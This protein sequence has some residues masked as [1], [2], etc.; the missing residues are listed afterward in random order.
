MRAAAVVVC[1]TLAMAASLDESVLR[2]SMSS[3]VPPKRAPVKDA[4]YNES[5]ALSRVYSAGIA[6][7]PGSCIADWSCGPCSNPNL[8]PTKPVAYLYDETLNI[9]GYVTLTDAGVLISFRGTVSSSLQDW[10]DDLSSIVT[11]DLP[12]CDGCQVGSGFYDAYLSVRPQ[13]LAALSSVQSAA[14]QN[15]QITGHSL[16]A[17]IA[18]LCAYDLSA[19]FP[20][21][22]VYTYG[23]P[24]VGNDAFSAAYNALVAEYRVTHWRDIVPHLPLEAMGFTHVPTEVWYV[25]DSSSYTVCDPTNGE[26]PNCSDS[27]DITISVD[28][29]L[30]YLNV[31]LSELC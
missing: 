21:D 17:A 31:M 18:S 6:Y 14:A 30:D 28:D 24:R 15:V 13:L 1:A 29:H 16:G 2:T 26:D 10:I 7:C 5:L 9:A 8:P 27:L 19:S 4:S 23:Q 22:V 11:V 20:I 25:E 12:G 3:S